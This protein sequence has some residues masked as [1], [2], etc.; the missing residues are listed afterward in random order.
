MNQEFDTVEKLDAFENEIKDHPFYEK[1][2]EIIEN[3]KLVLQG[4]NVV[5]KDALVSKFKDF[6]DF[7]QSFTVL[8]ADF[9]SLLTPE[10]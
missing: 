5:Y 10:I 3:A 1:F 8:A 4:N 6:N 7:I 9:K 2:K